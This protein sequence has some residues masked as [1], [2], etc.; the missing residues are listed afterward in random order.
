VLH[1]CR[2]G[3]GSATVSMSLAV[4]GIC[5]WRGWQLESLAGTTQKGYASTMM[6]VLLT[7]MHVLRPWLQS[8]GKAASPYSAQLHYFYEYSVQSYYEPY[9]YCTSVHTM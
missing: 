5:G 4:A 1:T 2:L 3:L 8:Y 7:M 9:M 6:H